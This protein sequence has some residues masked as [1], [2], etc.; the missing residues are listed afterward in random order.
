VPPRQVDRRRHQ[1]YNGAED[2]R[3]R[4]GIRRRLMEKQNQYRRCD[5]ACAYAGNADGK[6]DEKTCKYFHGPRVSLP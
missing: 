3:R 4:D 5:A 6:G 1:F 2:R